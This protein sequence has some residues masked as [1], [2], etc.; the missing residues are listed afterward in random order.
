MKEGCLM[1]DATL[2]PTVS[3]ALLWEA[4][5][6]IEPRLA[7]TANR[8]AVCTL[9]QEGWG[10]QLTWETVSGTAHQVTVQGDADEQGRWITALRSV[11]ALPPYIRALTVIVADQE[12]PI[13]TVEMLAERAGG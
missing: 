5:T 10:S 9:T 1:L 2:R 8:W 13:W 7:K 11:A 3:S 4:L 6:Q 12:P